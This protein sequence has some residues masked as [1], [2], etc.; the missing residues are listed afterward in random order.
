MVKSTT[1]TECLDAMA[2]VAIDVGD[3]M[4]YSWISCLISCGNTMAGIAPVTHNSGVGM[5]WVGRQK[6]DCGMTV[7]AF[8]VGNYM[9]FVLTCGNAGVT[10]G[11]YP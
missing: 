2:H 7:T 6:T 1:E 9:V 11:T 4:T 3:R 10:T 5:V 8:C